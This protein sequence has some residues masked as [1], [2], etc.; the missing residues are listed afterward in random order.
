M[1]RFASK[2]LIL[3][4]PAMDIDM[5]GWNNLF[6]TNTANGSYASSACQPATNNKVDS[7]AQ[8]Q[9]MGIEI[10]HLRATR[11]RLDFSYS[12]DLHRHTCGTGTCAVAAPPNGVLIKQRL[13]Y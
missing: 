11:L 9:G 5:F 3:M 4:G 8:H 7:L 2:M 1:M 13:V 12:R 10:R 6:S